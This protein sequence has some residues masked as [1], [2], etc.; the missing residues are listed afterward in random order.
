[1]RGRVGGRCW[2]VVDSFVVY[3]SRASN[4]SVVVVLLGMWSSVWHWIASGVKF[5]KSRDE[6]CDVRGVQAGDVG[7]H[8]QPVQ[9]NCVFYS[10]HTPIARI[11]SVLSIY[12]C[13]Y[14]TSR[15]LAMG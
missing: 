12:K 6:S 1:M 13:L 5:W 7:G 3:R 10:S 9:S 11:V 2:V 8:D 4:R 15:T 14:G